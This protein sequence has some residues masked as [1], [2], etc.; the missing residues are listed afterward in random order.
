MYVLH[1]HTNT[2][3]HIYIM[4]KLLQIIVIFNCTSSFQKNVDFNYLII[5]ESFHDVLSEVDYVVPGRG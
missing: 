5:K 4:E 3:T 2:H 1:T